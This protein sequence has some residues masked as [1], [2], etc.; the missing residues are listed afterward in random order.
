MIVESLDGIVYRLETL[1]TKSTLLHQEV[2]SVAT[3]Q[4]DLKRALI[5]QQQQQQQQPSSPS[6][7]VGGAVGGA[8]DLTH[9]L[10]SIELNMESLASAY[11]E[12]LDSALSRQTTAFLGVVEELLKDPHGGLQRAKAAAS[13]SPAPS[14]SVSKRASMRLSM[15]VVPDMGIKEGLSRLAHSL[16][17]SGSSLSV[18]E[19]QEEEVAGVPGSVAK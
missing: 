13:G 14:P 15:P 16:S 3:R 6:V 17:R 4:S 9:R 10:M 11:V 19:D 5:Q 2:Y 8:D 18:V 7:S 12:S 1:E